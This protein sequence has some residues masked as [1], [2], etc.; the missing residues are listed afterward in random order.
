LSLE[1][2][3]IDAARKAV[4]SGFSNI[5]SRFGGRGDDDDDDD[6]SD[7]QQ[8][9]RLNEDDQHHNGVET[10]DVR[11]TRS[12][13]DETIR[14]AI[15]TDDELQ[16]ERVRALELE[17][18]LSMLREEKVMLVD[19]LRSSS[20]QEQ[21]VKELNERL[22]AMEQSQKQLLADKVRLQEELRNSAGTPVSTGTGGGTPRGGADELIREAERR[23]DAEVARRMAVL[24]QSGP[25]VSTG[26]VSMVCQNIHVY[27]YVRQ[28]DM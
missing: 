6:E 11:F 18:Q 24:K 28:L 15:T 5:F 25:K 20:E 23:A 8:G 4:S 2:A 1:R 21:S 14:L 27:V 19:R 16:R 12:A 3:A 10:D 22:R 13:T 7:E 17:Q 26:I 9:V